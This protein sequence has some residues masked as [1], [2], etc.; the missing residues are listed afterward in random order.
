MVS[1][2]EIAK[3]FSDIRGFFWKHFIVGLHPSDWS[4]NLI[5]SPHINLHRPKTFYTKNFIAQWVLEYLS[6]RNIF[7][8][9]ENYEYNVCRFLISSIKTIMS[10]E[11]AH[12]SN[13]NIYI[14]WKIRLIPKK[15]KVFW[16]LFLHQI[17]IQI[18]QLDRNSVQFLQKMSVIKIWIFGS[19]SLK[20]VLA[21]RLVW[22]WPS[23]SITHSLIFHDM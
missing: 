7:L 18:F 13:L 16:I 4:G 1:T 19:K 22:N 14:S 6:G 12:C 5:F 21:Y 3:T 15:A 8:E 2:L 9:D 23:K 17:A 10:L 20:Y 11:Y